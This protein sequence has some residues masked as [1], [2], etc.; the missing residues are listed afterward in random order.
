MAARLGWTRGRRV[1]RSVAGRLPGADDLNGPATLDLNGRIAVRA[2]APTGPRAT[3]LVLT[4]SDYTGV[5]VRVNANLAFLARAVRLGFSEVGFV[6]AD[7]P[8]VCRDGRRTF[9]FQP[10]SK[11]S[12]IPPTDDV[13]RIESTPQDPATG[14]GPAAHHEGEPPVPDKTTPFDPPPKGN[15]TPGGRAPAVE[16]P[17]RRRPG[18]ADPGGR[19]AARCA[20]RRQGPG[21]RLTGASPLPPPERLV[22]HTLASLKALKLQDVAG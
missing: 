15:D 10:L 17:G 7:S 12:A 14:P 13:I 6:D 4:R 9:C 22:S 16:V 3:E 8:V 18:G 21:R 20:R 19:G 2:R 1:P 11:G 5:P